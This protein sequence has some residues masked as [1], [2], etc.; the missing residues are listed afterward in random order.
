MVEM[1]NQLWIVLWPLGMHD[2]MHAL[3]YKYTHTQNY[4]N[5]HFNSCTA[6]I[7]PKYLE[8]VQILI[9]EDMAE[10]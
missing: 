2:S 4:T 10:V 3:K 5:T 6:K 7:E 9:S 8:L 1:E